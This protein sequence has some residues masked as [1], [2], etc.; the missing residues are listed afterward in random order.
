MDRAEARQ[1]APERPRV[2]PGQVEMG[3]RQAPMPHTHPTAQ[4][5]WTGL[6][7]QGP[8]SPQTCQG[9][10]ATRNHPHTRH[11]CEEHVWAPVGRKALSLF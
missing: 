9:T 3:H 5:L 10:R 7:G 1:Q 4:T 11:Q 6:W 2:G 8:P